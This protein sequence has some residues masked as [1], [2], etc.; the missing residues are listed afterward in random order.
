MVGLP[1]VESG[2]LFT[3]TDF[4]SAASTYFAIGPYLMSFKVAHHNFRLKI[5]FCSTGENLDWK[6]GSGEGT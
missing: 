2:P 5:Q 1:E 6:L 4:K 3:G